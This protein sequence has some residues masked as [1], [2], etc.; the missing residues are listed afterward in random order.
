F[1]MDSFSSNT[2]SSNVSSQPQP[3][4]R[5]P[6]LEGQSFHYLPI[7]E[8]YEQFLSHHPPNRPLAA[9]PPTAYSSHRTLSRSPVAT[10]PTVSSIYIGPSFTSPLSLPGTN[11]NFGDGGTSTTRARGHS[12]LNPDTFRIQADPSQT[13]GTLQSYETP[14]TTLLPHAS[15]EMA[16]AICLLLSGD[17]GVVDVDS[18]TILAST[19]TSTSISMPFRSSEPFGASLSLRHSPMQPQPQPQSDLCLSFLQPPHHHYYYHYNKVI[20]SSHVPPPS[21]TTTALDESGQKSG[22]KD[23]ISNYYDPLDDD[24]EPEYELEPETSTNDDSS[25][26]GLLT[27]KSYPCPHCDTV[28]WRVGRQK[29]CINKHKGVKPYHCEGTC[30]TN[31]CSREFYGIENLHRHQRLKNKKWIC[32]D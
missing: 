18:H 25:R 8:D 28:Y 9:A 20:R 24:N 12:D 7:H 17:I 23:V 6:R 21:T 31:K 13:M 2:F 32:P 11:T 27:R 29:A 30:G 15:A 4:Q 10:S 22:H 5:P 26:S 19:S 14:L 3:P 16:D 1:I